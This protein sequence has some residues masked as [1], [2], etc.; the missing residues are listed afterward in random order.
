MDADGAALA[1]IA[2]Q[3][4]H[5]DVT[6][7]GGY[8]GRRQAP[9]RAASVMRLGNEDGAEQVVSSGCRLSVQI[10]F[11]QIRWFSRWAPWDSNPQ[12]KD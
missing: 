6:T 11:P 1:E 2:N 4:G 12:P 10:A 9:T 8:L 7:T 3:L 5:V